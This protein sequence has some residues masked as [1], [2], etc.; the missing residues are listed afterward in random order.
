MVHVYASP[1]GTCS[2]VHREDLGVAQ[3]RRRLERDRWDQHRDELVV[4]AE[5]RADV[6]DGDRHPQL[7]AVGGRVR[8][9]VVLPRLGEEVRHLLE[10]GR[11]RRAPD[12]GHRAVAPRSPGRRGQHD[13]HRP[14]VRQLRRGVQHDLQGEAV[15]R[16]IRGLVQVDR[17]RGEVGEHGHTL[18]RV[19]RDDGR[20]LG[21]DEV[22]RHPEDHGEAE[23]PQ[24]RA[25][26][27]DQATQPA[28]GPA[29]GGRRRAALRPPSDSLRPVGER[30]APWLAATGGSDADGVFR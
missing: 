8:R 29:P 5:V 15:H 16:G 24:R 17:V 7:V 22:G 14:R 11:V 3:A 26:L 10:P 20:I 28:L 30:T 12:G 27:P 23:E 18:D 13:V 1:P 4:A 19:V 25:V 21:I 6:R 2:A 9:S